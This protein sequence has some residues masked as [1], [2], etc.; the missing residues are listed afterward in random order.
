[1]LEAP[2]HRREQGRW[3]RRVPGPP[4]ALTLTNQLGKQRQVVGPNIADILVFTGVW[5]ELLHQYQSDH[6]AIGE[7]RMSSRFALQV[8]LTFQVIPDIHQHINDDEQI[9]QWYIVMGMLLTKD[10]V[11]TFNL[12]DIPFFSQPFS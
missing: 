6:L 11:G 2:Q 8:F 5:N 7:F 10:W 9:G 12:R 4:D 3:G 1:V